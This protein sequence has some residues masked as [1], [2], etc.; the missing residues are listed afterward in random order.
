MKKYQFFSILIIVM[1]CSLAVG[2]ATPGKVKQ[3][4][5]EITALN[6][7]L[8]AAQAQNEEEL[9]RIKEA[10]EEKLMR[11]KLGYD[12][13]LKKLE[14]QKQHEVDRMKEA[15]DMLA[16]ELEKELSEYKAKLQMSERG[17]VVTFLSEVFFDSGK[18]IIKESGYE[19]L[20]KVARVLNEKVPDNPV[21][22][23]GHTDNEPIKYSNWDS[24]WELSCHR[25]L[26]VLHY[27]IDN[28]SV[29]PQRL[30][31]NGYGEYKSVAANDTKEGKQQNRRV[32]IVIIPAK[33]VKEKSGL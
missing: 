28:C 5:D 21:A 32:E 20:N 9:K 26:A 12:A 23:E 24:N 2:C 22:I 10:Y 6:A 1:L 18:D 31:A 4:E 13:Q 17:L 29:A 25:A 8:K 7:K 15:K 16:K 30:S 27:F 33:V 14:T 3:L 11:S 19:S